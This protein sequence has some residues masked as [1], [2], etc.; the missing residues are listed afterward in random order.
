MYLCPVCGR[1]WDDEAALA[2]E[3]TCYRSCDAPLVHVEEEAGI[4]LDYRASVRLGPDSGFPSLRDAI[5]AV[6]PGGVIELPPGRHSD[7]LILDKPITI[8]RAPDAN[9]PVYVI[10]ELAAAVRARADNV[11]L[12]GLTLMHPHR[13]ARGPLVQVESGTL[14]MHD[15]TLDAHGGE[16]I[17][18]DSGASLNLAACRIRDVGFYGIA[19]SGGSS[20]FLESSS[21]RGVPETAVEVRDADSDESPT[22]S[23]CTGIVTEAGTTLDAN[24]LAI[25]GLEFGITVDGS[26]GTL[27]HLRVEDCRCGLKAESP[28]QLSVDSSTFGPMEAPIHVSSGD[29]RITATTFDASE[30]PGVSS[31]GAARVSLDDCSFRGGD[32]AIHLR[33]SDGELSSSRSEDARVFVQA[34]GGRVRILRTDCLGSTSAAYRFEDGVAAEIREGAIEKASGNGVLIGSRTVARVTGCRMHGIRGIAVFAAQK[35]RPDVDRC[36]ISDCGAGCYALRGADLSVRDTTITNSGGSAILLQDGA[37]GSFSRIVLSGSGADQFVS[38]V[39]ETATVLE[40]SDI[41]DGRA[42]GIRLIDSGHVSVSDTAVHGHAGS[43][44]ILGAGAGAELSAVRVADNRGTGILLGPGA[45]LNVEGGECE[46]NDRCG[47]WGHEPG[48]FRIARATLARNGWAGAFV[49]SPLQGVFEDTAFHENRGPGVFLAAP[50]DRPAAAVL[51]IERC[52]SRGNEAECVLTIGN[53]TL[54]ASE[55]TLQAEDAE[56]LRVLGRAEL[57]VTTCELSR[58][59]APACFLGPRTRSDIRDTT[60]EGRAPIIGLGSHASLRS[61][62]NRFPAAVRRPVKRGWRS[63]VERS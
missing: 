32:P 12:S 33:D 47:L 48:R 16:A 58:Q 59:G 19:C 43:G 3:K 31:S 28:R 49:D 37:R 61:R 38:G 29:L 11:R 53:I 40:E 39:S 46:E 23:G 51:R 30:G 35:S 6:K 63:K 52:E 1:E 26:S 62:D 10:A 41:R 56:C 22:L 13:N 20:V 21:I 14:A 27:R 8:R 5:L 45:I 17:R 50:G 60:F 42:G 34:E 36:D 9:G 2:N 24:H 44:I 54:T 25:T 7:P 18:V 15:C 4:H 57:T 55:C